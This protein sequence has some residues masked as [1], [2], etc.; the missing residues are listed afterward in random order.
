[1][2]A[3]NLT[4]LRDAFHSKLHILIQKYLLL[5]DRASAAHLQHNPTNKAR[6]MNFNCQTEGSGFINLHS[7]RV[8]DAI[9]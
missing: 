3:F 9:L 2:S 8:Q 7:L 1:M 6:F 4:L 5:P